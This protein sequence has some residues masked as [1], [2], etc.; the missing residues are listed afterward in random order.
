MI[1]PKP[2]P[3]NNA[4]L[5]LSGVMLSLAGCSAAADE[6][7]GPFGASGGA[8]NSAGGSGGG[9]STGPIINPG[10]GGQA[11][12]LPGEQCAGVTQEAN[13]AVL[14]VDVI[15]TIDTSCSMIQ[16][17][18]A[19]RD[20]MNDFSKQI[21]NAGVDVRIV[22]LA[23]QYGK[24][25]IPF[26]P[27]QGICIGA[28]LGSGSCPQDTKLPR[29][30]HI[31]QEVGS[32]N[33]LSLI[34]SAFPNYKSA[35]RPESLKIFTVVTDDNSALP[36]QDFSKQ[37]EQLDPS[38][39]KAGLWKM[40][41]IFCFSDCPSAARPG[42]VYKQIV[43][44]T[45]GVAG[46]LCKQNFKPVFDQLAQGVVASSQLSCGWAI[47]PPPDGQAFNK[48][49]VNVVFTSGGG[50][51]ATFGKVGSA[52]ECGPAGGWHYDDENNPDTVLVCPDT[53]KQIQADPTGKIDLQFGCSTVEVPK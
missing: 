35:L 15:W 45:Q 39:I 43:T 34:L 23:E 26:A 2:H 6:E 11:G 27:D 3:A 33:S 51:Q 52:A 53:C 29:F 31:Y 50:Q 36:A 5:L 12:G 48:G 28:P 37:V 10:Q 22:L 17:T 49:K 9:G 13:N 32:T 8:A 47:P 42:D 21:A 44:Q 14:P 25:P 38:Y 40:Y 1:R 30:A 46:D 4:L 16:E 19:V 18:Q 7:A 20:N 41:G 24:P